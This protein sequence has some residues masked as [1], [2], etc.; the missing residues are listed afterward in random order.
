MLPI[1]FPFIWPSGFTGE[2]FKQIS[3]SETRVWKVLYKDSSIRPDSLANMA[4]TGNSCFWLADFF[5]TSPLKPH[6]LWQG[7]LTIDDVKSERTGDEL[8]QYVISQ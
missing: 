4:A 6:Y 2:E 8:K 7:E 3:Q 1:K 5:K